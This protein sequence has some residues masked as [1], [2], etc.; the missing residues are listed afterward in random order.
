MLELIQIDSIKQELEA[1]KQDVESVLSYT[2]TLTISNMQ[3]AELATNYIAK[4]RDLIEK[5]ENKQ[6]EITQDSLNF[7][8][9][10]RDIS[11]TMTD[12]LK[13]VKSMINEKIDEWKEEN[14]KQLKMAE[15]FG[16]E[17]ID[18]FQDV[19]KTS[20]NSATSYEVTTYEYE[21]ED[22]SL[23][24]RQ[25]MSI[26]EAKVKLSLKSGVRNIPGLKIIKK[27]QTRVRRK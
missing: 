15:D 8:A 13:L 24:P 16:I 6:K 25:Y 21:I 2:R 11:K 5:I 1:H 14:K 17:I 27:T 26:D 3:D 19:S 12:P 18:T 7:V 9:K 4:A 23:V 20:T 10:I 22:E